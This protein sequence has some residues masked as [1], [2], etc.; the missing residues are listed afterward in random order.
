[1]P[2]RDAPVDVSESTAAG[3]LLKFDVTVDGAGQASGALVGPEDS[4]TATGLLDVPDGPLRLRLR[5]G[6]T[7]GF[8]VLQKRGSQLVGVLRL[9]RVGGEPEAGLSAWTSELVL[10]QK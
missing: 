9:G 8:V 3:P 4:L 2:N 1:M 7:H 10:A 5:S 6:S